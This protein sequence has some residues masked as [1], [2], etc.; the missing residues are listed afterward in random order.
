M[1]SETQIISKICK[2]KK[3]GDSPPFDNAAPPHVG[4]LLN[5][6]KISTLTGDHKVLQVKHPYILEKTEWPTSYERVEILIDDKEA[7]GLEWL[8]GSQADKKL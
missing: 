8:A 3:T 5:L 7:S 6:G 4:N 1:P 2:L